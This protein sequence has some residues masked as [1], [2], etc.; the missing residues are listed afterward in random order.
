[1]AALREA[2]LVAAASDD[3]A[4]RALEVVG[5]IEVAST[6][7]GIHPVIVGGMA[8]YFWTADDTF[9]THDIDVVMET[10]VPLRDLLEALGFVPLRDRRHWR[11][12]GT[13]VLIE[14]PS[15]TL[16]ASAVVTQVALASGRAARIISRHDILLDRLDEF[17]ATGHRIAVQQALVLLGQI[18][19][20]DA[21][22]LRR[23]AIGRRLGAVLQIVAK[24]GAALRAGEELPDTD[25]LH[26]LAR[27]AMAAEYP[28][29]DR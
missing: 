1:M 14:A 4:E 10:P 28:L 19:E 8:V 16:E 7:L 21:T 29:T 12:E 2:L 22:E 27:E 3:L 20:E 17:Q 26:A 15:A 5:I 24:L 18:E 6:P 9:L 13:D 23:R 25:V 11:L